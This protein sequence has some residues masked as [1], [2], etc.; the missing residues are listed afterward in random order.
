MWPRVAELLIG[1]W[2]IFSRFVFGGTEAAG[3]FMAVDLVVG[4]AVVLCAAASFWERTAWARF[5]T[6]LLAL[7]V[8]LFAYVAWPR[9]GPPSA[10]NEIVA[11]LLLL[12]LAIIPNEANRPPRPW[13]KAA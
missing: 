3:Q 2:L 8:G 9:P 6:L 5:G 13:R 10:Q 11:A 4:S 12:M 1:A 7:G